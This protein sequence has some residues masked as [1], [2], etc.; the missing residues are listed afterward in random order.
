MNAESENAKRLKLDAA[1]HREIQNDLPGYALGCLVPEEALRVLDHLPTCSPC[2]NQLAGYEEAV[3]SLAFGVPQ[4]DPPDALQERLM[5]RIGRRPLA[6]KPAKTKTTLAFAELF[7]WFS[8]V[9]ATACLV[10]IV[11][12]SVLNVLQWRES[13]TASSQLAQPLKIVKVRGTPLAPH[14]DGTFVIGQSSTQGVLVASDLPSIQPT[15]QF[16]LWLIRD[17]EKD[18]GGVFSTT[19]LGYA[20]MPVSSSRPL[21]DYQAANVTVEPF[22][23]SPSPTGTELMSGIF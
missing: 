1:E 10:L 12:L 13:R 5:M 14:A 18:S 4:V 8:P 6:G 16:Q 15:Q 2:R 17:G 19:P 23:G 20:V 22:G 3:G 9:V 21:P 11:S 7:R